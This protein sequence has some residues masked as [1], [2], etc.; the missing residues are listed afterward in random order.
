MENKEKRNFNANV[1]LWDKK[2]LPKVKIGYIIL[3]AIWFI[4]QSL[5]FFRIFNNENVMIMTITFPIFYYWGFSILRELMNKPNG[6]FEYLLRYYPELM[7][8][9]SRKKW[10]GTYPLNFNARE[11][12]FALRRFL[13]GNYT[14]EIEDKIIEDMRNRWR[15]YFNLLIFSFVLFCIFAILTGIFSEW[16][17]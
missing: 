11:D 2:F 15:T 1:F 17:D 3:I 16:R 12:I 9:L 13:N 10:D 6:D 8:K 14:E 7:K 5:Y 4:I